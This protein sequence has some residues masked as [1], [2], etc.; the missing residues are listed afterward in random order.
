MKKLMLGTALLLASSHIHAQDAGTV[1]SAV[2]S[3]RAIL[4]TNLVG[5]A[6]LSANLNY[7]YKAGL[8]TSVGL[9]AGYKI[10]SVIHISALGD[11]K[12]DQQTY[13]GDIEPQGLFVNPYFRFYVGQQALKGF[14]LE[15]FARYFNYTF[16]VPYDYEKNGRNIRANLDGTANGMGGGLALGVQFP[17]APRVYLDI[18]AGYGMGSGDIHVETNDPNL[19][20][21]DYQKIKSNIEKYEDDADVQI[22]VLE[23]VLN[24][25]DAE[26]NANSAWADV[27]GATF[28]ILRGGISVGFAF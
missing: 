11:L 1:A 27:K 20:A 4:K 22:F 18:H 14:Y 21:A 13:T 23:S 19:D 9:L 12:G 24:N 25:L 2:F 16:L 7:E 17:V 8:N 26:A 6:W 3:P 10:P 28:P 15:A 5:Y